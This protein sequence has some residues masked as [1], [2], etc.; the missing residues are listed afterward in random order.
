MRLLRDV[1]PVPPDVTGRAEAS[2]SEPRDAVLAL[3][4]VEVAVPKYPVPETV[5]AVELAYGNVEASVVE[6]ATT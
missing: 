4:V 6:V 3:R 1:A 2:V 5:S